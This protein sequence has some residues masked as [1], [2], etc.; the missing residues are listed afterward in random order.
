MA[1]TQS[2]EGLVNLPAARAL[3][4]GEIVTATTLKEQPPILR[5][6]SLSGESL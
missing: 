1:V 6:L 2:L 5:R 3:S 4:E